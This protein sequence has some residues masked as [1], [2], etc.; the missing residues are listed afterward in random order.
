MFSMVVAQFTFLPATN[1]DSSFST[2]SLTPGNICLFY[3]NHSSGCE[4][5]MSY[6]VGLYFFDD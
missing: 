1:K 3:F 2:S 6:G 4:V 5:V